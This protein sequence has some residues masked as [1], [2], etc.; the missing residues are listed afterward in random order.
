MNKI[1]DIK[2]TQGAA[3]F[4]LLDQSVVDV[5][6]TIT[7]GDL[8]IR[9]AISWL[10]FKQYGIEYMPK[11]RNHG[12]TKYTFKRMIKFAASGITGFSVRPLQISTFLG[13]IFALV[14]FIYGSYAI[15]VKL[16][17]GDTISGWASVLTAI[18]FIGGIQMVMIGI[19][20]EYL[21]KVFIETKKR[22]NYIIK[23]KSGD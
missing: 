21:G 22:P 14:A 18:L 7:E 10:G 16:F 15:Y 20:G 23:E 4:R 17:T 5:L 2:I 12:Q 1:T 19:L 9:G 3:D 11:K 8:F 6:K 13:F